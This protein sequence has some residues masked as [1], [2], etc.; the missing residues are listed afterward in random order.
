MFTLETTATAAYVVAALV[1][2]AR[3]R[4]PT[5]RLTGSFGAIEGRFFL[6]AAGNGTSYGGGMRIT[7]GARL[8]DGLLDLCIVDDVSRLT[9]LRVLPGVFS[10]SHI[11]HP[12]VRVVRA[13]SVEIEAGD[14][15]DLYADGE[16]AA[17]LPARLDVLPGALRVLAPPRPSSGSAIHGGT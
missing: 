14:A 15:L 1:T 9:V 8:D 3:Y 13:A 5:L 2:L 4:A 7:P 17:R 11:D 16:H 10:G 12:A 6:V